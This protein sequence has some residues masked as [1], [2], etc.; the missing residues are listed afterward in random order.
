MIG[1]IITHGDSLQG[2]WDDLRCFSGGCR[3]VVVPP[4][5]QIWLIDNMAKVYVY[6][7]VKLV[8][9]RCLSFNPCAE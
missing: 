2:H 1:L 9:S 8:W 4:L 3:K 7:Y 6:I 5:M